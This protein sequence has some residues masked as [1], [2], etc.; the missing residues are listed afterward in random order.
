MYNEIEGVTTKQHSTRTKETPTQV[1]EQSSTTTSTPKNQTFWQRHGMK[2]A[3]ATASAAALTLIVTSTVVGV[4]SAANASRM[5]NQYKHQQQAIHQRVNPKH[6]TYK[7]GYNS[8]Y[9]TNPYGHTTHT[10]F[11]YYRTNQAQQH[12]Y[13]G[14]KNRTNYYGE[15]NAPTKRFEDAKIQKVINPTQINKSIFTSEVKQPRTV[16]A[17]SND[18]KAPQTEAIFRKPRKQENVQQEKITTPAQEAP[19]SAF[20]PKC[21][22][23]PEKVNTIAN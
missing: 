21:G 2:V 13:D 17:F 8:S 22:C 12:N 9:V 16:S 23:K 14:Y 18:T 1:V 6:G 3:I 11:D 15:Q 7:D 4:S 5:K 10:A 19:V 20:G